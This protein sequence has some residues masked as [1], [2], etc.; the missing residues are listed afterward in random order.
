CSPGKISRIETGVV[1]VRIQDARE[2]LDLYGVSG[3][4]REELLELVR[5]SRGRAWWHEYSDIVPRNSA[6]RFGLEHTATR[7][8]E[9]SISLVPGLLQTEEYAR[10]I[11]GA[12]KD[13]DS[14]TIDRRVELRLRRQEVLNRVDPPILHVILDEG[15]LLRPIGGNEIM[16]DQLR[17]LREIQ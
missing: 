10:A 16:A 5:Q 11:I 2:L 4:R 13:V 17:Y 1:G 8:S 6:I 15:V 9:H 3:I 7:L 12:A 14:A